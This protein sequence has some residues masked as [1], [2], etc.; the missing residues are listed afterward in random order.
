MTRLGIPHLIFSGVAL[1]FFVAMA[2]LSLPF[3][4]TAQW[5]PLY[6][7]IFG[8]A[9]SIASA[10]VALVAIV[11]TRRAAVELVPVGAPVRASRNDPM[12]TATGAASV[13]DL[14][15]DGVLPDDD[16][17]DEGMKTTLR[18]FAWLGVWVGFVLL[19]LLIGYVAASALWIGVWFRTILKWRWRLLIPVLVFIVALLLFAEIQLNIHMPGVDWLRAIFRW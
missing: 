14:D 2:F 4:L 11:R 6:V 17:G 18:G 16:D 12:T 13:V 19:A 9:L 7:G 15:E 10:I 3:P 8:A 5:F 1:A